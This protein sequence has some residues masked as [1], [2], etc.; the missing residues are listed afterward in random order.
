MGTPQGLRATGHVTTLEPSHTGRWVW[1]RETRDDSGVFPY[2]AVGP[3]A[4]GDARALLYR[5][6]GLEPRDTWRQRSPSLPGGGPYRTWQRQSPPAS[7][8]G[9]ESWD[10]WRH[11]S[12]SQLGGM[13]GATRHVATS[14]PSHT[15]SGSGAVGICSDTGALSCQVQC[16]TLE[17]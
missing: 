3:A 5:E 2:Q 12:P 17:D 13:P 10:T 6:A 9:L 16:L 14:K 7:G 4:R 11:R 1:S 8:A 15:G